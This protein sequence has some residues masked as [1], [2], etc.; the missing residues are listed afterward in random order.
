M[1]S[2]LLKFIHGFLQRVGP[3]DP[4]QQPYK[5]EPSSVPGRADR[6]GNNVIEPPTEVQSFWSL[7]LTLTQFIH[8]YCSRTPVSGFL[9]SCIL[10]CLFYFFHLY[11]FQSTPGIYFPSHWWALKP[12]KHTCSQLIISLTFKRKYCE[13]LG[14]L[15]AVKRWQNIIIFFFKLKS[16]PSFK[17]EIQAMCK[18]T[19]FCKLIVLQIFGHGRH[20][21][22]PAQQCWL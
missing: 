18:L 8:V 12:D 11:L 13:V 9:N 1:L 7:I 21:F 19:R 17:N 22:R 16:T 3:H 6:N 10:W 20:D 5:S 14:L 2:K 15:K 4:N